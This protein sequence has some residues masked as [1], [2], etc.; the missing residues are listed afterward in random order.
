MQEAHYRQIGTVGEI[1]MTTCRICGTKLE[2]PNKYFTPRYIEEGYCSIECRKV[3]IPAFTCLE[4]GETYLIGYNNIRCQKE[5]FCSPKCR[6][7]HIM[8]QMDK[9]CQTCGKVIPFDDCITTYKTR[10]FCSKKCA[11][12][13]L[14]KN[15][16][17]CI[18]EGCG[19]KVAAFGLC[20]QHYRR[21]KRHGDP[22]YT[23]SVIPYDD[24]YCPYCGIKLIPHSYETPNMFNAN[25]TYCSIKCARRHEAEQSQAKEVPKY[26]EYCGKEM[27][28]TKLVYPSGRFM[29]N[30]IFAKKRFCSRQCS[31]A[32][33]KAQNAKVNL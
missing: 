31:G 29:Q 14:H 24:K 2:H 12:V 11:G 23:K 9:R 21:L 3:D 18:I 16:L 17:F 15:P 19:K 28:R 10:K 6:S 27:I 25:R 26:C 8:T 1:N 33:R 20:W 32:Y 5:G 30:T 22:N 4:C 13:A 7:K